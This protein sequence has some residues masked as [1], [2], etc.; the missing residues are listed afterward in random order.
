M[1]RFYEPTSSLFLVTNGIHQVTKYVYI[2][3]G[4]KV[5]LKVNLNMILHHTI[6]CVN[7]A[8]SQGYQG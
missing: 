3:K 4:L 1:E 8:E 7:E 6:K 5:K 2:E